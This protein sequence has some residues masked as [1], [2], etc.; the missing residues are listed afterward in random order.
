MGQADKGGRWWWFGNDD[1]GDGSL[2]ESERKIMGKHCQENTSFLRSPYL[3]GGW[4][5]WSP[6]TML[7]WWVVNTTTSYGCESPGTKVEREWARNIMEWTVNFN[8]SGRQPGVE[9]PRK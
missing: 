2:C 9:Y 1:D 5:G 6:L 7:R 8:S 3:D 4:G